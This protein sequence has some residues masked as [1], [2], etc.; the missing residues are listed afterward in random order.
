MLLFTMLSHSLDCGLFRRLLVTGGL[1]AGFFVVLYG[2][3]EGAVKDREGDSAV[4]KGAD[5]QVSA[6]QRDI[7]WLKGELARRTA[8]MEQAQ[9]KLTAWHAE[10][11]ATNEVLKALSEASTKP[12]PEG[13][14]ARK[15]LD[16]AVRGMPEWQKLRKAVLAE[17]TGVQDI[18][19]RLVRL[20]LPQTPQRQARPLKHVFTN[21]TEKAEDRAVFP[22]R[23]AR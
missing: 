13:A 9:E 4:E 17:M 11:M 7:D 15:E 22:R 6:R 18:N 19:A 23:P 21:L 1:M 14:V 12:D 3:E 8:A 2:G 20:E 10:L 5:T 16:T